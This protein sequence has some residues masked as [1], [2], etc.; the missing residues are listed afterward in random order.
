MQDLRH[1]GR[2]GLTNF[3]AALKLRFNRHQGFLGAAGNLNPSL[4]LLRR[5]ACKHKVARVQGATHQN[6]FIFQIY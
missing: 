2:R 5:A 4:A 6:T 1:K 3:R